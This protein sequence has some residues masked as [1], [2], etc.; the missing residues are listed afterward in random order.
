MIGHISCY[1]GKQKVTYFVFLISGHKRA[2]KILI[3]KKNII[4]LLSPTWA[5]YILKAFSFY[6]AKTNL[7]NSIVSGI[8]VNACTGYQSGL[9]PYYSGKCEHI[10]LFDTAISRACLSGGV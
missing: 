5:K 4:S 3:F 6:S 2:E 1:E 8:M 9:P 7:E 10:L